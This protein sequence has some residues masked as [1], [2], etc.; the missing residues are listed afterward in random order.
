MYIPIWA[1]VILAIAIGLLWNWGLTYKNNF[2][3]FYREW[4]LARYEFELAA[5]LLACDRSNCVETLCDQDKKN[6]AR[7]M[8]GEWIYDDRWTRWNSGNFYDEGISLVREAI[9]QQCQK[10]DYSNL[11]YKY[12]GRND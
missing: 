11:E 5:T 9:Y 12:S 3:K 8:F 1:L 6:L 10:Y 2:I 4:G 7:H